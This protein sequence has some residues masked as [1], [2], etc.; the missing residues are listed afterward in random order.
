MNHP[1]IKA[2][3]SMKQKINI[4]Y[5]SDLVF[6]HKLRKAHYVVIEKRE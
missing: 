2:Y 5:E 4:L 1:D 3:E 6:L